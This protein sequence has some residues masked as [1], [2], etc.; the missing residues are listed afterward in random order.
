MMAAIARPVRPRAS[1]NLHTHSVL[2]PQPVIAPWDMYFASMVNNW[3]RGIGIPTLCE[4]RCSLVHRTS[5]PVSHRCW[6]PYALALL[7]ASCQNHLILYALGIAEAA[8]AFVNY[9]APIARLTTSSRLGTSYLV[10]KDSCDMC[11]V[12]VVEG[13]DGEWEERT[14]CQSRGAGQA[15]HRVLWSLRILMRV[16][17]AFSVGND[18]RG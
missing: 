7:G 18:R 2:S 13:R 16:R 10:S 17:C 8:T 6:I 14:L 5:T 9:N 1:I 4:F 11:F 15:F 3:G 12:L